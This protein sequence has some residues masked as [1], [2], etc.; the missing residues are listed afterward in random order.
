MLKFMGF[1]IIAVLLFVTYFFFI[2]NRT[3]MFAVKGYENIVNWEGPAERDRKIIIDDN[4]IFIQYTV[5]F[6]ADR[7]NSSYSY[8]TIKNKTAKNLKILKVEFYHIFKSES[9]ENTYTN[10]GSIGKDRYTDIQP[11]LILSS[12]INQAFFNFTS[13]KVSKGF[14]VGDIINVM[15]EVEYEVNG[16]VL[17]VNENIPIVVQMRKI[18]IAWF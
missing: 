15:V 2:G 5:L 16:Q 12:K 11:P 8:L 9:L 3:K 18:P 7:I 6:L 14:N 13:N 4:N 1:V 10:K 17:T